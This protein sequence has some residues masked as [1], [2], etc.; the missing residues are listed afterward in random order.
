MGRKRIHP[1]EE[2]RK[3]PKKIVGVH[4]NSKWT[5]EINDKMVAFFSIAPFVKEKG[6]MGAIKLVP[7]TFPTFETFAWDN[8]ISIDSLQEWAKPENVKKYP[9]F[10][11]AFKKCKALQQKFLHECAA[12][13]AYDSRWTIF[14]AKNVTELRDL[15]AIEHTGANG[16]AIQIANLDLKNANKEELAKFFRD[17][18]TKKT[19]D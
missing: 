19:N 14:F 7:N 2:R 5:P 1:K 9:G 3:L 10:C 6:F 15:K 13:K 4:G 12:N 17:K 11:G 8:D 18:F 16:G